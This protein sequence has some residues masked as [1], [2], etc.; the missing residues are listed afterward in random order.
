MKKPLL[1]LL[2]LFIGLFALSAAALYAVMQ[3][4]YATQVVNG[5]FNYFSSQPI[6]TSQV[7]Y[8]PPLKFSLSDVT[9]GE[10][11]QRIL[12]PKLTLWLN[13]IPWQ[14]D[15]LVVDSLL[16]EGAT[17]DLQTFKIEAPK[18]VKLHQLALKQT[19]IS[20]A[21]WSVR[22]L[23]LQVDQPVW[24]SEKQTLPFG[25]IQLSAEQLY[26]QGEAL[27]GLLVDLRYQPQDSTIFGSSFVWQGAKISGQA[28]QYPHGWS[29][30]NVTVDQ[31]NLPE[32]N[33][34]ETLLS[35]LGKLHLPVSH[36]NSLDILNSS[37]NY[38]DWRFEQL[39]ASLE[40]LY[41]NHS[42][43][44]QQQGYASFNAESLTNGELRLI[45]PRSSLSLDPERIQIE[46]FD[47]DF[48]Q[49]RV[50]LKG[51]LT[52]N[53]VALEQLSISALKWLE[54]THTLLPTVQGL[55][56]PLDKLTI[57]SL[58]IENTQLIQVER[59][60]YWQLSGLNIEG[61]DLILVD[62]Q[63]Q[64]L[65]AGNLEASANAVNIDTLIA[66]QAHLTASANQNKLI[67]ER[68]FIPLEQ[69]YIEASGMW[70]RSTLS[71]PWQ[72]S[73]HADGVPMEHHAIQQA[74]PF[75]LTGQSEFEVEL[76][77]LS[78]DY[79][80][81]SHSVSGDINVHLHQV[82]LNARSVDGEQHYSQPLDIEQVK[83]HVDRG[84]ITIDGKSD[85]THLAGQADLTKAEYATILLKSHQPCLEL[86][87]DI[88]NRANVIK[89]TC[90]KP[91]LPQ[92][93][94]DQT[95]S[96][97]SSPNTAL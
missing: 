72:L 7:E 33:Q 87:S 28:E 79:S 67:L 60:P 93:K 35:T 68:A 2:V 31:L 22:G 16:I 43:W 12:L 64:G 50:Q 71:A 15:Q 27:D 44:Q 59:K 24:L 70:D 23:N 25:D 63:H 78:G 41:L 77:G 17:L 26:I 48:K 40:N 74:L 11:E 76:S 29:L 13:Q 39:D 52:P 95:S 36:I 51:S 88:L 57:Q 3:T 45:S 32:S 53:E 82:S 47:A 14:D 34:L 75:T 66:T 92:V 38:A 19:D 97:P 20:S 65:L 42:F 21:N 4:R 37:F 90:D 94:E 81:L 56:T 1:L 86:W 54:E 80:M 5:F 62:G 85:T 55:L 8:T 69:G 84:R 61:N 46:E 49:G 96:A 18:Q 58:D 6:T 83:V 30:V 73:L 9:I 89:K 10:D 91:D